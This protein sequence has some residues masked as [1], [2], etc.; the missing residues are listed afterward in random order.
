MRFFFQFGTNCCRPVRCCGNRSYNSIYYGRRISIYA[1]MTCVFITFRLHKSQKFRIRT[2]SNTKIAGMNC[3]GYY[4]AAILLLQTCDEA[5]CVRAVCAHLTG[6]ILK[7]NFA[8]HFCCREFYIAFIFIY[9]ITGRKCS[10]DN[11]SR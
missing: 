4:L 9:F 1:K 6:V 5:M 3:H 7:E 2:F 10:C 11:K 8:L